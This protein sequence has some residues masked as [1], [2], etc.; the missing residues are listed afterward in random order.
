M[1]STRPLRWIRLGRRGLCGCA[2]AC[3]ALLVALGCSSAAAP[4][5]DGGV[6]RGAVGPSEGG[7]DRA[8]PPPID[9]GDHEARPSPDGGE[10]RCSPASV[11]SFTP[12]PVL[13]ATLQECSQAQI[14]T[15]LRDCY[16]SDTTGGA[17]EAFQNDHANLNC[18][19]CIYL[20]YSMTTLRPGHNPVPPAAKYWGPEVDVSA[21]DKTGIFLPNAGA[22]VALTDPSETECAEALTAQLQCE[23]E[24]CAAS[25]PLLSTTL[26]AA[27]NAT[28]QNQYFA[29]ADVADLNGCLYYSTASAMTCAGLAKS[30]ASVCLPFLR[31]STP[32][33]LAPAYAA[34]FRLECGVL[35]EG[36][37]PDAG[38]GGG[39]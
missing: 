4:L 37:A 39:G 6:D 10:G 16:R 27:E 8:T 11:S 13:P 25:C 23:I 35:D 14:D 36:G 12:V 24:S 21:S 1:K 19:A 5:T 33:E 31:A 26:S 17:C 29:C 34:L 30:P 7:H 38:A 18:I 22:C 28:R 32:A 9:A 15:L 3:P 2:G 20:P